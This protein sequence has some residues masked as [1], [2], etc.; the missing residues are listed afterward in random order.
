MGQI[1]LEFDNTLPKSDIIVPMLSVSE[2]EGSNNDTSDTTDKSQLQVFGIQVPLIMINNTV[3]DF[4]A[5]SYFSL[6]S[7]G[8]LP[9]LVMTVEDRYGLIGNIDKPKNDNEVRVQILPRFDNAYKKINMT[10][11]MSNINVSGKFISLTC[12]YKLPKLTSSKFETY[13]EL[14]TFDIFK[15]AAEETGLGF[16]TNITA[17]SDNRYIYCDN[18]S[19]LD[20]LNNEIQFSGIES[21][22]LDW[23]IDFWDNINL[24][25]IYERYKATDSDEDIQVWVTGQLNETQKDKEISCNIILYRFSVPEKSV[26]INS[27][28]GKEFYSF[29]CE[30]SSLHILAAEGK[31]L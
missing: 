11:Y 8:P 9:S 26:H 23:W 4:D 17:G 14:N 24:A 7:N 21:Q 15:T 6:K 1:K 5:V 20:I 18:K 19:W 12:T 31:R 30:E 25:D 29:L 28:V 3:I 27:P 13:G 16:A 10:F 2:G 22:V